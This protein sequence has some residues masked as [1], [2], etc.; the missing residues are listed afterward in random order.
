MRLSL[1]CITLFTLA[2]AIAGCGGKASEPSMLQS[3]VS[4]LSGNSHSCGQPV[5]SG[6]P[7]QVACH[8]AAKDACPEGTAPN[9]VDF[10]EEGGLFLVK[11]YSCV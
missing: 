10:A 1:P 9:R 11:G 4:N 3:A 7:E 5:T 8:K 2:F 6:S